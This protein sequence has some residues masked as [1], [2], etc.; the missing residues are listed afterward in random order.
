MLRFHDGRVTAGTLEMTR[1]E[2]VELRPAFPTPPPTRSVIYDFASHLILENGNQSAG[3]VPWAEAND[4]LAAIGALQADLAALRQPEPLTFE[5][6][7]AARLAEVDRV[8]SAK[9]A[10]GC[11]WDFADGGWGTVQ[12]R[13]DR[14]LNNINGIAHAAQHMIDT[15]DPGSIPVTD[16]ENI[17]HAMAPA[18][19]RAMG[20]AVFQRHATLHLVARTHKNAIEAM[21]DEAAL[22]GYDIETGW[23]D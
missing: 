17:T 6:K 2:F 12:T 7:K 4:L 1:E 8:R 11:A 21:Q 16:A 3:P 10:E 18:E 14:D 13:N 20:F 23:P 19:A 5:E 9:I 15:A 22:D